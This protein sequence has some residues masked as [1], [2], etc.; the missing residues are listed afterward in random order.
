MDNFIVMPNSVQFTSLG[1]LQDLGINGATSV[2]E[3]IVNVSKD[4]VTHLQFCFS[5]QFFFNLKL[6]LNIN[7]LRY[8]AGPRYAKVFFAFQDYFDRFVFKK[9]TI[10]GK[11]H[12]FPL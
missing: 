8:A 9:A 7:S 6:N 12:V 1:L 11:L 10:F 4:T 5:L 2:K 3:L